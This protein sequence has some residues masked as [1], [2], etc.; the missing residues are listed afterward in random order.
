MKQKSFF[1]I[2]LIAFFGVLLYAQTYNYGYSGDDG[3]YA[4]FNRVTQKGLDEWT[5]LFKY[6]SMNFIQINPVNTSIYRPFTLLTFAVEYQV[7]GEFNARNGH[8]LNVLLYGSLLVVLGLF[9]LKLCERKSWPLLIP[10]L[11]LAL[12]A[13]HPLHVEVVASVKSRDTLLASLFAFSAILL[14]IKWE[15]NLSIPRLSLV[16]ILFF[17]SL[18]SKEESLPLIALVA[19]IGY[20]FQ[21]KSVW[22][23]IKS[24]LPFVIPALVYLII[25]AIVLDSASTTYDSKINSVIYGLTGGDRLATNLYIYLQY[26]KLLFFPHPLSWDYSFAQLD[27]QTFKSP[28]VWLSL[29]FFGGLIYL[30]YLGFKSRNVFSFG[31]LFY[32]VSFSIFANL[33][34]SL[35]IGSNLGERFLFIPSLAFSFLIVVGLYQLVLKYQSSKVKLILPLVLL[36]V[37][38]A[39]SWKTIDRSPV[40]KSNLTLSKSGVETAPKSW[41]THVMYAEELRLKGKEIEKTSTDSAKAYYEEAIKEFDLSNEILGKEASVSQ[42]LN[43]L[44]EVLLGY[45]DTLRAVKVFEESVKKNPAAYFGWFKLAML[46]FEEGNFDKAEEYYL[47]SLKS[48]KTEYFPNYKNLGLTYMRKGESV[49]AIAMFE[50]ALEYQDDPS[51]KSTLS[52]L[53]SQAGDMEKAKEYQTADST[54]RSVEEMTFVFTMSEAN[55]AFQRND[56]VT[57]VEKYAKCEAEFE[58]YGGAEK[59][60]SFNAAYAKSLLET[61][62]TLAAKKQFLKAYKIDP[63]NPVVLTNL[64]TIAFLK[65]KDYPTSE[66]YYR[67]A[68]MANPEDPFS[69][70][71]N[72]GSVLLAQ[73]KEKE[74]LVALEKSLEYGSNRAVLGNLYLIN[75]SLGNEERMNYYQNLLNQNQ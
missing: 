10:L 32:L 29:V 72:L 73:R 27:V 53:Y 3:I 59:Y 65:D 35:I 60:P 63:K 30:A 20:F 66:R 19:L 46:N 13:V 4:Y 45:G 62:D 36:P 21:Q 67:E 38:L 28:I 50:K 41:R 12:Y 51:T 56:Y 75:K 64:G 39:F 14:W 23:S 69:A 34:T 18:I 40:W 42:Y 8:S 25:R 52:Y 9:L 47:K 33:T 1:W 74:G 68:T 37:I 22:E 57:A 6:G 5:E 7:F 49:K 17:F 48:D 43:A 15:K 54:G 70:Y 61:R 26:I 55:G 16:G 71:M 24:T 11:I 31:I 2:L 58:Q 44:G